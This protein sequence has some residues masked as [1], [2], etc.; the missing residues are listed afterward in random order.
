M[1]NIIISTDSRMTSD[2]PL[3]I[4][5]RDY[6]KLFETAPFMGIWSRMNKKEQN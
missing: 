4:L 1:V 6:L 2:K 5:G 3:S